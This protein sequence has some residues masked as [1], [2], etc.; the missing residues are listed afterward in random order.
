MSPSPTTPAPTLS[1]FDIA[2]D[3][4]CSYPENM[5]SC[6]LD[7]YTWLDLNKIVKTMIPNPRMPNLVNVWQNLDFQN[8]E[9]KINLNRVMTNKPSDDILKKLSLPY[10]N[11][12]IWNEKKTDN[13]HD[14]VIDSSNFPIINIYKPDK[15]SGYNPKVIDTLTTPK[16]VIDPDA[17]V[18]NIE[19]EPVVPKVICPTFSPSL[20]EKEYLL[21]GNVPPIDNDTMRNLALGITFPTNYNGSPVSPPP[22]AS[23]TTP[24]SPPLQGIADT[25]ASPHLQGIAASPPPQASATT[26]ASPPLQ[27][28]ADTP[29]SAG[30]SATTPATTPAP[31]L[32][33]FD[34]N[35]QS[36]FSNPYII[37]LA[38]FMCFILLILII[39]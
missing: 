2:K 37:G 21:K 32:S 33:T 9:T 17:W 29:A 6:N 27:G 30:V 35:L 26:P 20:E 1:T 7:Y 22:Q 18:I 13:K 23:A 24:A 5:Y 25:P 16:L 31:T 39:K 34:Q 11:Y 4:Y 19:K 38:I 15:F 14:P 36:L 28:V 8:Y 10:Y 12:C 3:I